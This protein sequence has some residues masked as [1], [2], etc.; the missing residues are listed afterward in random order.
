MILP[1]IFSVNKLKEQT[2]I[3][4][5]I[6]TENITFSRIMGYLILMI[7]SV[8]NLALISQIAFLQINSMNSLGGVLKQ[9]MNTFLPI[10][11]SNEINMKEIFIFS[12]WFFLGYLIFQIVYIILFL[13]TLKKYQIEKYDDFQFPGL[14]FYKYVNLIYIYVFFLPQFISYVFGIKCYL[15]IDET[16]VHDMSFKQIY[17]EKCQ[18]F[19]MPILIINLFQLLLVIFLN[20]LNSLLLFNIETQWKNSLAYSYSPFQPFYLLYEIFLVILVFSGSYY[21]VLNIFIFIVQGIL[22]WLLLNRHVFHSPDTE[23]IKFVFLCG[24]ICLTV[25]FEI[26]IILEKYI[27]LNGIYCFNVLMILIYINFLKIAKKYYE[28]HIENLLTLGVGEIIEESL[29]DKKI[30]FYFFYIM[31]QEIQMQ[32]INYKYNDYPS[33]LIRGFQEYHREHCKFIDCLCKNKKQSIYDY[34]IRAEYQIDKEKPSNNLNNLIYIK[35]LLMNIYNVFSNTKRKKS[36]FLRIDMAAFLFYQLKNFHKAVVECIDIKTNA[37]PHILH[38][39]LLVRLMRDIDKFQFNLDRN[40]MEIPEYSSLDFASLM[41]IED[42]YLQLKTEIRIFISDYIKFLTELTQDHPDINILEKASK[43]LYCK[44]LNIDKIFYRNAENPNTIRLYME[45]LSNL[46]FSD[47]LKIPFEKDYIEKLGLILINQSNGK[48]FYELD[49]LYNEDSIILQMGSSKSNLG[50]IIKPNEGMSKFVGYSIAEMEFANINILMPERIAEKHDRYLLTFMETSKGNVIYR[51]RTVFARNKSGFIQ[52]CSLLMKP[53][54]DYS[55][56]IFKFV[57]YLQPVSGGVE[58]AVVDEH[59]FI[60]SISKG[61]GTIC[62]IFATDFE[63]KRLLIQTFS[64]NLA[65]IFIEKLMNND[66]RNDSKIQFLLKKIKGPKLD[67][68]DYICKVY[69]YSEGVDEFREIIDKIGLKIEKN[70]YS[71]LIN[72]LEEFVAYKE[73]IE[74]SIPNSSTFV[75]QATQLILYSQDKTLELNIF[76]FKEVDS[77]Y[78]EI[79]QEA[80]G[81]NTNI[82]KNLEYFLMMKQSL[83]KKSNPKNLDDNLERLGSVSFYNSNT[84][85]SVFSVKNEDLFEEDDIYNESDDISIHMNKKLCDIFKKC[86]TK[87]NMEKKVEKLISKSLKNISKQISPQNSKSSLNSNNRTISFEENEENFEDIKKIL[88]D[89]IK[90]IEENMN[91]ENLQK[92]VS[93]VKEFEIEQDLNLDKEEEKSKIIEEKEDIENFEEE[94]K[95]SQQLKKSKITENFSNKNNSSNISAKSKRYVSLFKRNMIST[96]HKKKYKSVETKK[97]NPKIK[98]NDHNQLVREDTE[99]DKPESDHEL[100]RI[101][102]K[103]YEVARKENI[104]LFNDG[105][106]SSVGSSNVANV[107]ARKTLRE[108]IKYDYIP[109]SFSKFILLFILSTILIFISQAIGVIYFQYSINKLSVSM[110][111]DQNYQKIAFNVIR[112]SS[113]FYKVLLIKNG[114]I[115]SGVGLNETN[116]LVKDYMN[117]VNNDSKQL[118]SHL[119]SL[120]SNY[121]AFKEINEEIYKSNY[122]FQLLDNTIYL[123]IMQSFYLFLTHSIELTKDSISIID[124][125][126]E[127]LYFILKNVRIYL[128]FFETNKKFSQYNSDIIISIKEFMWTIFGLTCLILFL[129]FLLRIILYKKCYLYIND[130]FVMLGSIP[131][132]DLKS[133]QAYLKTMKVIFENTFISLKN[134]NYENNIE[135]INKN[136]IWEQNKNSSYKELKDQKGVLQRRTKFYK[137]IIFPL[138]KI[139]LIDISWYFVFFLGFIG[140]LGLS[141]IFNNQLEILLQTRNFIRGNQ[142]FYSAKGLLYSLD[143]ISRKSNIIDSSFLNTTN[144]DYLDYINIDLVNNMESFSRTSMTQED[145]YQVMQNTSICTSVEENQNTSNKFFSENY[146]EN[147]LDGTL[148]FGIMSFLNNLKTCMNQINFENNV[149]TKEDIEKYLN[150]LKFTE[151]SEGLEY[152]IWPLNNFNANYQILEGEKFNSKLNQLNVFIVLELV[153]ISVLVGLYWVCFLQPLKKRLI[154]CRKC[155]FHIPYAVLNQQV[156]IVKYITSTGNQLLKNK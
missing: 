37:H 126:N 115:Y 5:N 9:I 36:V 58:F 144:S 133:L 82:F 59:G 86:K 25:F 26:S 87:K 113:S 120:E 93:S 106:G 81:E 24:E 70:E 62:N 78:L 63:P 40:K 128:D 4:F 154:Y 140:L 16:Y 68:G 137:Y 90:I 151:Y 66:L 94:K 132:E 19:T 88:N 142:Y 134:D 54:F 149:F 84:I 99:E 141:D 46:I 98:L 21:V 33:F 122:K 72:Y 85:K 76:C 135:V 39:I 34:S 125:K 27:N 148:S 146:C 47:D 30:K 139:L 11:L 6:I 32:T 138:S 89:N 69:P 28:N 101:K 75:L 79:P 109:N 22:V 155:F 7:N 105:K 100:N 102:E 111:A 17:N 67:N 156:R 61:L 23:K 50:H 60:D 153:S 49:L 96:F 52:F 110:K 41:R 77:I 44:R 136:K 20:L 123:M 107:H 145:L 131:N 48:A 83:S 117:L 64:P 92:E 112:I 118:I 56:D 119:K 65:E 97:K 129:M 114:L 95:M 55:R 121:N 103:Q 150:K 10:H 74:D 35:H 13:R 73:L 71:D 15:T 57:G 18:F 45:Y 116:Q 31:T 147:L 2:F 1:P 3:Y 91:I 108:S 53:L 8:Q 42:N 14:L 152:M 143:Y 29:I 130:I 80:Y 12:Y 38:E 127:K 124:I 104:G 51:E 43:D